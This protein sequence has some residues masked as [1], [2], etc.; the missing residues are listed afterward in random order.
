MIRSSV[1]FPQ[2][3]GPRKQIISPF[4]TLRLMSVRT[5]VSLY[6]F[7]MRSTLR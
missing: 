6:R 7:S 5:C 3:D 4:I 2:P 1:V